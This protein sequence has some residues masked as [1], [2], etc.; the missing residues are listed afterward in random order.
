MT[1]EKYVCPASRAGSLDNFIRRIIHKPEKIFGNYIR[2]GITILDVGCGPGFFTTAFAYMLGDKGKVI[3]ADLQKEMLDKVRKKIAGKD[4]E[5]RISLH[6]CEKDKIDLESKV[7][8]VNAFYMVHEVPS[9][10]NL[11]KEIYYLLKDGGILFL[12]EPKFH[13]SK[14]EFEETINFAKSIGFKLKEQPGIFMS[15]TVVFEK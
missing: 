9:A 8:F 4:I 13:V 1:E 6:K 12:S 10:E 2:E 7:D 11:L 14:K 5:K 15:R 3:A